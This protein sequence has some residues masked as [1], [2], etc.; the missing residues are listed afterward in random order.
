MSSLVSSELFQRQK[1]QC[2]I[3]QFEFA[4]STLWQVRVGKA[5]LD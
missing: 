5:M 3:T 4:G 1:K 2:F